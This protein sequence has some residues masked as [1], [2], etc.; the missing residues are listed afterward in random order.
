MPNKPK[1]V[2]EVMEG[3]LEE[4][5]KRSTTTSRKKLPDHWIASLFGKLQARYG[6]TFSRQWTTHQLRELAMDE[7]ATRLGAL[8]GE[9]IAHGLET[10][11]GDWPP[12]VEQFRAACLKLNDP[13]NTAAYKPFPPGLPKPKAQQKTADRELAKI[14]AKPHMS[15]AEMEEEL[16]RLRRP[17]Y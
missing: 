2:A 7:W 12:N 9:Q 4:T 16:R 13:H 1:H 6:T 17:R 8:T 10:W 14:R 5:R 15:Q 3:G 11:A